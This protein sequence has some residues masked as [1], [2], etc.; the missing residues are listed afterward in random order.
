MSH[1]VSCLREK[2]SPH[3]SSCLQTQA[4]CPRCRR[5]HLGVFSDFVQIEQKAYRQ[6]NANVSRD[7]G[8]HFHERLNLKCLF[9]SHNVIIL[10]TCRR[11]YGS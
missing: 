5:S 6:A 4:K 1:T 2:H 7:E 3:L 11:L 8:S 10:S 9:Q